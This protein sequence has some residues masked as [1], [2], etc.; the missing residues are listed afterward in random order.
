MDGATTPDGAPPGRRTQK[1][2]REATRLALLAAAVDLVSAHG[3]SALRLHDVAAR[4]GVTK[5]ALQHHFPSKADLAAAVTEQGWEV[6]TAAL[7]A[8]EVSAS[9]TER[10]DAAV[11]ALWTAYSHP[12]AKAGFLISSAN[13]RSEDPDPRQGALTF[14]A[15]ELMDQQWATLFGDS[16]TSPQRVA[17]ARRLLRA[18]LV[19]LVS[20]PQTPHDPAESTVELELLKEALVHILARSS[21]ED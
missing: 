1:A 12:A 15:R 17:A 16:P 3:S 11:D 2:R 20:Y 10:V 8:V 6:L 4:A 5:G 7:G 14:A 19:G 21:A 9:L 13:M 18:E